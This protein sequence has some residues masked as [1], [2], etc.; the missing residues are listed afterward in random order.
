MKRI[1]LRSD[2]VTLPTPEM[3]RAMFEAP[4]GDDVYGED[5]TINELEALAAGM[6]GKEAAMFVPSGSQGNQIAVLCH[7]NRGEEVILEAFSHIYYYEAAGL[8]A[9]AACQARTLPSRGGAMD[10]DEVRKA[11]RVDNVHAPRTALICIENT[12]NVAGGTIV[13]QENVEAI[14]ALAREKGIA[15]HLDGARVFNAA[16]ATGRSAADL[17][18][19]F[20]TVMFCLSKG[21]GAPVGSIV[22]GSREFIKKAR[23]ARKLLGGGMRQAGILAAAGIVSLKTMVD[24]LAEDHAN[25]RLLAEQVA[26]LDGVSV[27]MSTVQTNMVRVVIADKRWTGPTLSGALAKVGVP[28]NSYLTYIRFVTHKEITR[29]DIMEAADRIARVLKAGPEGT[30]TGYIYG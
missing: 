16:V 25:A 22:A 30:G 11:I 19:P 4:V 2:T 20:D 17:A 13:P 15:V 18:A 1:D 6:V 5:P 7:A 28:C 14:C 24:R 9:I 8:A 23:R 27:D 29:D 10:P 3:R 26:K 12:H 21:L